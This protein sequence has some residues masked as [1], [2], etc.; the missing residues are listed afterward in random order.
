MRFAFVS[1]M[2]DWAWGGSEELW[3]QTAE[4]LNRAGHDVVVSVVHRRPIHER[5]AALSKQ[6][7][8][9]GTHPSYR[10]EIMRRIWNKGTL[11]YRGLIAA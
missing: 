2:V 8:K 9:V 3:S 10:D 6:G 11:R 7:I 1:T 5:V 4:Q